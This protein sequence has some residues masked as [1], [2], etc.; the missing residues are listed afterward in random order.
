MKWQLH[1]L[2]YV[3]LLKL[4]LILSQ[5]CC[6]YGNGIAENIYYESIKGLTLLN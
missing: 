6:C 1:Y 4:Y 3:S 2:R 5:V